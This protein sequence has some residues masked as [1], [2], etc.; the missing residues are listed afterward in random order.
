MPLSGNMNV[1]SFAA[2]TA[3]E[4]EGFTTESWMLPRA[5]IL[6]VHYEINND[7]I[8]DLLP[9][10]LHPS[11]PAWAV[12]NVMHCPESPVGAFSIAEVRIGSR[13]GVRPRG[14]VLRSYVDSEAAAHELA[15]RWGYPTVVG[16]V[17]LRAFHDRV[18]ARVNA[19]DGKSVLEVEMI[20]REPIAGS[21]IQYNSSMHLARNREDGKLLLVQLDPSWTFQ[22]VERG[23]PHVAMLN[24]EAWGTGD[25][26]RAEYPISASYAVCDVTLGR[27]RY[28]CDPS[29]DAFKGTT[30]IAA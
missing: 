22:K 26:L 28:V 9:V 16:K 27:I 17:Y 23:R 30:A 1:E 10:T 24:S 21:D 25:R 11:I 8:C 6:N 4:I 15:R 7:T 3:R 20:D 19:S 14:F 5:Q 29:V 18:V 12:F 2:K 13:A